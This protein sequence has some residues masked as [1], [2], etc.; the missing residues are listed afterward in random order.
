MKWV[1]ERAFCRMLKKFKIPE[2]YNW[3]LHKAYCTSQI[4][5]KNIFY[6]LFDVLTKLSYLI[7]YLRC[8]NNVMSVNQPYDQKC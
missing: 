6:V 8:M 2:G 5:L 1:K 7:H 3:E 4:L